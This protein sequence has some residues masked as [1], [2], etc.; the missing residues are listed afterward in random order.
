ML[1]EEATSRDIDRP[2]L[3]VYILSGIVQSQSRITFYS[4]RML[5]V[6][7][8]RDEAE[9]CVYGPRAYQM[10][11]ALRERRWPLVVQT[12]GMQSAAH[13]RREAVGMWR[14]ERETDASQRELARYVHTSRAHSYWAVSNAVR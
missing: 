7:R 6:D 9:G 8:R 10:M 11:S 2:P 1:W 3:G 14:G 13:I 4:D 12:S 5:S